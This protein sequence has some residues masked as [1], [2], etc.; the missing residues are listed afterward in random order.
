MCSLSSKDREGK[1]RQPIPTSSQLPRLLS[2]TLIIITLA[3]TSISG[4]PKPRVPLG[5]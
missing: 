3:L 4:L 5:H 2:H 1:R